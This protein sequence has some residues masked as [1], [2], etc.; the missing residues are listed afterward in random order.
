MSDP[1][2]DWPGYVLEHY[3][4]PEEHTK[5]LLAL[6]KKLGANT[7][8]ADYSGGGDEGGIERI[9]IYDKKGN[10]LGFAGGWESELWTMADR[11]LSTKF[12]SWA[13][14]FQADGILYANVAEKRAW[15]EGSY[16][17]YLDSGGESLDVQL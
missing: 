10:N 2:T 15:T 12:Y 4:S 9:L 6:L 14:E 8:E 17:V 5:K 13:G 7:M 3:G 11:L 16:M 1:I